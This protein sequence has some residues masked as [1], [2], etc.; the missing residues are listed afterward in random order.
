[1]RIHTHTLTADGH[2]A[3][4]PLRLSE[5]EWDD[6]TRFQDGVSARSH[7]IPLW[8]MVRGGAAERDGDSKRESACES[9]RVWESGEFRLAS[10]LSRL[11]SAAT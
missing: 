6:Y 9:V 2:E 7:A 4:A 5:R 10:A 11:A 3:H 1:M 8:R